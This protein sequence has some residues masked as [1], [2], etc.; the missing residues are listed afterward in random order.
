MP[1]HK[2]PNGK[3]RIGSGKCQYDSKAKAEKAYAGYR[4]SKHI[5]EAKEEIAKFKSEVQ[6]IK[7]ELERK[8]QWIKMKI[9]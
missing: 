8:K 9:K 3:F 6:L 2:C 1:V 7:E 4:A 5:N